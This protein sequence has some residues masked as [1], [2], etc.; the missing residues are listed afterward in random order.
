MIE[1]ILEITNAVVYTLMH[2]AKGWPL[3]IV[4]CILF[5]PLSIILTKTVHIILGQAISFVRR[6]TCHECGK[7]LIF[8]HRFGREERVFCSPGC[9][10][11]YYAAHPPRATGIPAQCR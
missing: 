7:I 6:N 2:T 1:V 9:S 10:S 4:G 3:I 8:R 5:V 11:M